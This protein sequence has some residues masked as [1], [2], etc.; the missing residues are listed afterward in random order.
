MDLKNFLDSEDVK[1]EPVN[2]LAKSI[3]ESFD[4]NPQKLSQSQFIAKD[5]QPAQVSEAFKLSRKFNVPVQ[6][7]EN[8]IEEFKKSASVSDMSFEA[9]A[10]SSPRLAKWL[11][12][13]YKASASKD[14]LD[15]L[16]KIERN[17]GLIRPYREQPSYIDDLRDALGAGWDNDEVAKMH[18]SVAFGRTK[19]ED[20]AHIVAA[21]NQ[22]IRQRQTPEYTQKFQEAT[23][24][25]I[26]DVEE[27][28]HQVIGS[29][30]ELRKGNILK[31]WT[32]YNEGKIKTVVEAVD[33]L[34][35]MTWSH[36]KAIGRAAVES[37]P[38]SAQ[39]VVASQATGAAGAGTGAVVAGPGGAAVGYGIGTAVGASGASAYLETASWFEEAL[40][41]RGID[42]ADSQ[43]LLKA[44]KD[45]KLMNEVRNEALRRGVTMGLIEAFSA[46]IAGRAVVAAKGFK[47]QAKALGKEVVGQSLMEG[48]QEF[49]GRTAAYGGD[50][51]KAGI[52]EPMLEATVSM[53]HSF[54]QTGATAV[55]K[56]ALS[57]D[58]EMRTEKIVAETESIIDDTKKSNEA[59]TSAEA[60]Q[61][62]VNHAR[63]TGL[64]KNDPVMMG[65]FIGEVNTDGG[66][67]Q[68]VFFQK[69]DLDRAAADLGVSPIELAEKLLATESYDKSDETGQPVEVRLNDF[70]TKVAENPELDNLMQIV[71]NQPD[72][73]N[74]NEAK[75]IFKDLPK[76]MD[77]LSTAAKQEKARVELEQKQEKEVRDN[78]VGQLKAAGRDPVDAEIVVA[79]YKAWGKQAGMTVQEM[80]DSF[81]LKI[82]SASDQ[83]AMADERVL[84][85][86]Q[87]PKEE[88]PAFY[89]KMTNLVEQKMGKSATVEQVRAIIKDAKADEVKWSGIEN[90]LE[91]KEKVSK[92]ELM[93][94]LGDNL[95]DIQ[96]VVLSDM[97]VQFEGQEIT[98]D[99][100]GNVYR[101][102]AGEDDVQEIHGT[103]DEAEEAVQRLIEE[104]PDTTEDDWPIQQV[105]AEDEN[106]EAGTSEKY[107][108]EGTKFSQYTLPGG[109]NYR[110]ILFVLPAKKEETPNETAKRLFGP[111]A[112][113]YD[114]TK[115]QSEQVLAEQNKQPLPYTSSHFDQENILAHIRVNERTDADGNR[116]LFVEEIQSDW[117]QAGRKR[118]YSPEGVPDAPFKKNWHEF[119]FKR[120]ID[121]AVREGFDKIAWTTGEQQAE[122]YDLSK[123]V[124]YINAMKMPDG[125][126]F[127]EINAGGRRIIEESMSLSKVEDTIG[128]EMAEKISKQEKG[129]HQYKGDDLKVGG[130]GMKGFYDN[131]LVKFANKYGKKFKSNVSD[132]Q[133]VTAGKGT[134]EDRQLLDDLGVEPT[135]DAMTT[136]HSMPV[137]QEMRDKI[138][139]EGQEFY[140]RG[141]GSTLNDALKIYHGSPTKFKRENIR[142]SSRGKFGPGY[143]MSA[144][145]DD[146]LNYGENVHEYV[147]EKSNLLDVSKAEIDDKLRQFI[148]LHNLKIDEGNIDKHVN[149]YYEIVGAIR[150]AFPDED[151]IGHSAFDKL[152]S[153]LN[154]FGYD[155]IKFFQNNS[156]QNMVIFERDAFRQ[157]DRGRIRI[158]PNNKFTIDLFKKAD[159]STFIHESGHYFLEVMKNLSQREQSSQQL[160]DD[161]KAVLDWFGV[162]SAD[163]I[164]VEHHEKWARGYELYLREGKAPSAA[165][166][167]AFNTFKMW[168]VALYKRA[169][170]LN[171][172]INDDIRGVMDRMMATEEEIAQARG[173]ISDGAFFE[174]PIAAGMD[175]KTAERYRQ[176]TGEVELSAKE[177]MQRKLERDAERR[178]R[179][180][181]KINFEELAIEAGLQPVYSA[182]DV[183]KS[184]EEIDGKPSLKFDYGD[185]NVMFGESVNMN[186]FKGMMAQDDTGLHPDVVA[187]MLGFESGTDLVMS[188]NNA[189]DRKKWIKLKAEQMTDDMM[190]REYGKES[191]EEKARQAVQ[192]I[193][194]EKMLNIERDHIARTDK[195]LDKKLN[196]LAS[197][198]PVPSSEIKALA[199][200]IISETKIENIKPNTY[201]LA[202]NRF[203]N[204]AMELR[205]K[206]D[207]QGVMR[208]KDQE[209]LNH[210]LYRESIEAKQL[211]TKIEK[212]AKK[213]F[214]KDEKIA[215]ARDMDLVSAG[216][217]ILAR[218]G[219]GSTKKEPMQYIEKIKAYN[220]DAYETVASII[221]N[222][223]D[224]AENY[225]KISFGKLVDLHQ[226]MQA[227][228][229]LSKDIKEIEV[230]GEKIQIKKAVGEINDQLNV[231]RKKGK[232]KEYNETATKKEMRNIKL[233][234]LKSA[235][236]RFENWIDVMDMG[237]IEGS[238]RKFVWTPVS[239]ALDSYMEKNKEFKKRMIVLSKPLQ[240]RKE[241]Q[242]PIVADELKF[243]GKAFRFKSKYE[244][245]GALLHTGNQ[246]NLK[247]LLIGYGWGTLDSNGELI[248]ANWDKFVQRMWD[249]G[250]LTKEDYDYVQ[251][252]WDLME[253]IKPQAQ[254][255]H[256]KI[257]GYY[258]DEITSQ[259]IKTPFGTYRGGYAP[260]KV[261]PYAVTDMA[262]RAELEAFVKAQPNYTWPAA[263]GKGFTISRVENFNKPLHLDIGLVG[264][265][266]SESL[267]F[268]IV[269]PAVVDAAK[270]VTNQDFKTAVGEIDP[271]IIDEMIIPALNRAD[272]NKIYVDGAKIPSIM[273]SFLNGIRKNAAMQLMFANVKNILEQTAGFSVA[274]TRISPQYLAASSARYLKNPRAAMAAIREKSTAMR[275]RSDEQMFEIE[276]ISR[277]IFE[278]ETEWKGK[279]IKAYSDLNDWGNK[280]AYYGQA[281]Y[282]SM[283]DAIVWQAAYDESI[284]Q[285]KTEKQ[286]IRKAD[287]DIRLTQTSRRSLDVATI[288][289]HQWLNFFN[290]FYSFFLAMANLNA[291]NFTKLY[292]EDLGLAKKTGKGL[293]LYTMGFASVA[294]VS[295]LM[296]KAA[297]GGLDED[298][299]GEIMDDLYDVFIGSQLEFGFAMVPIAG[300]G[301]SAAY[302]ELR[303]TK[304]YL[305]K[306][307]ASP[308]VAAGFTVGRTASKLV[309]GELTDSK[310]KNS[311]IRDGLNA[312]GIILGIPAGAAAKPII[313]QKAISE[314]KAK[315]SGPVDYVRGMVTGRPGVK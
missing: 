205:N 203:R 43:Q 276:K 134:T 8:N 279:A 270:I 307:G 220:P 75:Q 191:I 100:D 24:K 42:T 256:K 69:E 48:G 309:K 61:N 130:E 305:T 129:T 121:M 4:P 178:K 87:M 50:V 38:F 106:I 209:L 149:L 131:M 239:E 168:L 201:R 111:D 15:A 303:G 244:L 283:I 122:R 35:K 76:R 143:Y 44:Y 95:L 70:I 145:K 21:T 274:A 312:T 118:G 280:H 107:S 47:G 295:A 179:M 65:E 181:D 23:K 152:N 249:E 240:N 136:V 97:K 99:E 81:N 67:D 268:A 72:G 12:D 14:D 206:G 300:S 187:E 213:F 221:S 19:P 253:E 3:D 89:S 251:G 236:R 148:D 58:K 291:D 123:Q 119:A 172:E 36:K 57:M 234:S 186:R 308:A 166:R 298:E 304:P 288:E 246:S 160:K 91:G 175:E 267:R 212:F 204:Q 218:Y 79:M 84:S 226:A 28:I 311:E 20:V 169:A 230:D 284:A 127:L 92:Q 71:K 167:K 254:Q 225:E 137:T 18:L 125:Q 183:L 31:A 162:E 170:Q 40:S 30:D 132:D 223:M 56:K 313:Y 105:R 258:F 157:E 275:T 247:K 133:V 293:Y 174:D 245:I 59:M 49:A 163:Q 237:K 158:S 138:L 217:A 193:D 185:F 74:L 77:E 141:T 231:F 310:L 94:F 238:F 55:G 33:Y 117:H 301:L 257:F 173:E 202:M 177:E 255:A 227:L 228:W 5:K 164:T 7:V 273:S 165:L 261:D 287:A 103:Y 272:K 78:L 294:A 102:W 277:N 211:K 233:L 96:T 1:N 214:Q 29:W 17:T 216:R 142:P 282:Q 241:Y 147:L 26:G 2:K 98:P 86:P 266:I 224:E 302:H 110:E 271:K 161:F 82:Q 176:A 120:I 192:N 200:R 93:D 73:K 197:K 39:A 53:G 242:K 34:A 299:D 115:E 140:Q 135:G 222:V 269:K 126:Y 250:V 196:R 264:N 199:K 290:M 153:M 109:E 189:I 210:Y 104:N 108:D 10:A 124:D 11:E 88:M 243:E 182:I 80:A 314:G 128:K 16:S 155:G 32:D 144:D 259:E 265:H 63:E 315:P 150:Q 232:E 289:T 229:S 66:S 151:L 83:Q 139:G 154:E 285:G 286:A 68:T 146:T 180:Q 51:K 114:L 296:G 219:L 52:Y 101:V 188:I 6:F 46:G 278:F 281:L 116:V 45:K 297:A 22:R 85:Q 62:M 215:K 198:V 195:W 263:G 27:G 60:L 156:D 207:I 306:A 54:V 64:I 248:T 90:F 9:K 184:K 25:E 260:A 190:A 194:R 41:E 171:V 252:L 208:A 262:R 112:Q 292:Y 37:A 235:F 113:Y 159:K 13:P